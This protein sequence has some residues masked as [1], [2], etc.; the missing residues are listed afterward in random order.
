MANGFLF[1]VPNLFVRKIEKNERDIDEL[2]SNLKNLNTEWVRLCAKNGSTASAENFT[3]EDLKNFKW[4]IVGLVCLTNDQGLAE[5]QTVPMNF[6]RAKANN[7]IQTIYKFHGYSGLTRAY[8]MYIDD[9]TIKLNI[10]FE[11][12]TYQGTDWGIA[13]YGVK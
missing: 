3:V 1:G 8:A 13:V 12:A 11:G 4:I 9:T 7:H 10:S 5:S 2:N 6:F